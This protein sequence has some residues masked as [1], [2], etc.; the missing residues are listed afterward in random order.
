MISAFLQN[1]GPEAIDMV[2]AFAVGFGA[3]LWWQRRKA[4]MIEEAKGDNA[5]K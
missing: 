3:C 1:L 5:S 2:A 4:D